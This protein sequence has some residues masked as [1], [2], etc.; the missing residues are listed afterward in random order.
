MPR[1]SAVAGTV[2]T[3]PSVVPGDW[4]AEL[5][6]LNTATG[7]RPALAG[8]AEIAVRAVPRVDAA[9]VTVGSP[10]EPLVVTSSATSAQAGDARQI[11]ASC[12]PSLDAFR[13]GGVCTTSDLTGDPRW[14][15]LRSPDGA[16]PVRACVAAAL[17]AGSAA[18]GVLTLYSAGAGDLDAGPALG[19]F[20]ARAVALILEAERLAERDRTVTQLTT[21]LE[22]RPVIDQAKGIIMARNHCTED[23]AFRHLCRISSSTN[24]KVRDVARDL[25][26]RAVL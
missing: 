2:V 4:V 22:S 5:C 6:R 20:T 14:P 8:L 25:V 3:T 16:P 17:T 9:S 12:G 21:A 11:R 10:L 18:I 24:R 15:D 13:L 23:E 7:V 1:P 19:P 26:A